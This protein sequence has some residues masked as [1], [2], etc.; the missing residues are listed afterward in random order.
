M[1]PL[2]NEKMT[3]KWL[4][5]ARKDKDWTP[6]QWANV[7]LSDEST[8]RKLRVVHRD[9]EEGHRFLLLLFRWD[10]EITGYILSPLQLQNNWKPYLTILL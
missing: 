7:M 9:G 8:F 2:I 5:F 3:E 4:A 10:A 6:E 1:K